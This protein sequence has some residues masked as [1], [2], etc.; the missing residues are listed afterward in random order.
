MGI[1]VIIITQKV[2]AKLGLVFGFSGFPPTRARSLRLLL[3]M[4]PTSNFPDLG[5]S[6]L[7]YEQWAPGVSIR[8]LQPRIRT[9]LFIDTTLST[10]VVQAIGPGKDDA[11]AS[12]LNSEM[13]QAKIQHLCRKSGRKGRNGLASSRSFNFKASLKKVLSGVSM[14]ALT[15][16]VG[17]HSRCPQSHLHIIVIGALYKSSIF[18]FLNC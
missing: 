6:L 3:M 18:L 5:I 7:L 17:Y 14:S 13:F 1:H 4:Q 12:A 11:L 9:M 2:L 15:G 10:A 8:H 16:S